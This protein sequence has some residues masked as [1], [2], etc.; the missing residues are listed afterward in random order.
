MN[1]QVGV[2]DYEKNRIERYLKNAERSDQ[3]KKVKKDTSDT[4][5]KETNHLNK[6]MGFKQEQ[7]RGNIQENGNLN[8]DYQKD[9][10]NR[11][12]KNA[13]RNERTNQQLKEVS[14]SEENNKINKGLRN[15]EKKNFKSD[16]SDNEDYDK[17]RVGRILKITEKTQ[18]SVTKKQENIKNDNY[19]L[20]RVERLLKNVEKTEVS[21]KNK[22]EDNLII[23]KTNNNLI[24][25]GG[26]LSEDDVELI[27]NFQIDLEKK[28]KNSKSPGKSL[29]MDMNF[30]G[31]NELT[32]KNKPSINPFG[33]R[34]NNVIIQK[35]KTN[36]FQTSSNNNLVRNEVNTIQSSINN[37]Q[38][39]FNNK[40]SINNVNITERNIVNNN[41]PPV[42]NIEVIQS[43][44]NKI[45]SSNQIQN[46]LNNKIINNQNQSPHKNQ[47]QG[48]LNEAQSITISNINQQ[49][50]NEV[51]IST[52]KN[53]NKLLTNN[54]EIPN[55]E[56][57]PNEIEDI[58]LSRER[59]IQIKVQSGNNKKVEN[60][61]E[62]W[63]DLND[64][65]ESV[66]KNNK[67]EQKELNDVS[68]K[69]LY[70]NSLLPNRNDGSEHKIRI[71]NKEAPM[72][73]DPSLH[74]KKS[75]NSKVVNLENLL[76]K[77]KQEQQV[78]FDIPEKQQTSPKVQKK[79]VANDES[80]IERHKIFQ[81]K[82]N[83]EKDGQKYNIEKKIFF[84]GKNNFT[85][86]ITVPDKFAPPKIDSENQQDERVRMA[87]ARFENKVAEKAIYTGPDPNSKKSEVL[88]KKTTKE[89]EALGFSLT[90]ENNMQMNVGSYQM[91]NTANK[92]TKINEQN[93]GIYT[94]TTT[95]Y[96][97][98]FIKDEQHLTVFKTFKVD[99]QTFVMDDYH[100]PVE[101]TIDVRQAETEKSN[102]KEVQKQEM[103][104]IEIKKDIINK[105]VKKIVSISQ[106][107]LTNEQI[108]LGGENM[109]V[110]NQK[111]LESLVP[112]KKSETGVKH[113]MISNFAPGDES[114]FIN[115]QQNFEYDSRLNIS[116]FSKLD[117]DEV[118]DNSI[119]GNDDEL[120]NSNEFKFK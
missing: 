68:P 91:K 64:E 77:P 49:P 102:K 116:K 4:S 95:N 115:N 24:K 73:D 35:E 87:K 74:I 117:I 98:E 58:N 78:D 46:N 37:N 20:E 109:Q 90:G 67:K 31:D 39:T 51:I 62:K 36:Y 52:G 72:F 75:A 111:L 56:Y 26:M 13:E 107:N 69:P 118:W 55:T 30:D 60:V 12:L 84:A 76:L 66:T 108:N 57:K 100:Q 71:I 59:E 94:Q 17:N 88:S 40:T 34:T 103:K 14:E 19:E 44:F 42:Q 54:N 7:V 112:A 80:F 53:K 86:Q 47:I 43:N 9:R 15:N 27:K 101:K 104:F 22:Q 63:Q 82:Q 110:P 83:V 41:Q 50:M 120:F 5:D 8:D 48:V 93:K 38:I 18:Q 99:K 85:F 23:T 10:V 11:Y 28:S 21:R 25:A 92:N 1:N 81:S 114:F 97:D 29:A 2:S 45:S 79:K 105:D 96:V 33:V 113:S 70:I 89:Q 32:D 65:W 61:K 3:I 106:T 119:L 6:H 16:I